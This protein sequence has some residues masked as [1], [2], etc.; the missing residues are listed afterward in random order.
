[1][2]EQMSKKSITILKRLKECVEKGSLTAE[3][4]PVEDVSELIYAEHKAWIEDL[5]KY[6]YQYEAI[7][8]NGIRIAA[9]E[10][11]IKRL[12][13][14]TE[15]LAA[16]LTAIPEKEGFFSQEKLRRLEEENYQSMLCQFQAYAKKSYDKFS[17]QR[18]PLKLAFQG[19]GVI[20]TVITGG[21]DILSKP[22][23]IDSEFDYV[24]FTDDPS[25]TSDLWD[26]RYVENKEGLDMARLSRK[27]KILC[28]KFLE[29]YDYSIYIDGKLQ[30][31]GDMKKYLE[32][33]SRGKAMLCFPHFVRDCAYEE[34]K[35][36]A[37]LGKD[38]PEVIRNQMGGYAKEGYPSKHGLT[39]CACMVRGH[40][41]K[42][43]QQVM[44]CWWEEVKSK[45][46]RDQLSFG[47]ACWKN[48]FSYDLSD[49]YTYKNDF[50]RKSR[51]WEASY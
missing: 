7:Y 21:Y 36:C 46:R 28:H 48:R 30:I 18:E 1:M 16:D 3:D 20:Y 22:E 47:Y 26:I 2:G 49:L 11:D 29:E 23:Y 37:A 24:C 44:E 9:S 27:Y 41:D 6:F 10:R 19:K 45:S 39:D 4:Y 32:L 5:A 38:A 12:V 13:R 25:L 33:Y 31:I 34:A 42:V 8:S 43:L 15:A 35:V 51:A 50:L 17:F 40:R 14:L